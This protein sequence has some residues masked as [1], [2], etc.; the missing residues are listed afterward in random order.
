MP[1]IISMT[2][3][4]KN[5]DFDNISLDVNSYENILV[6]TKPLRIWFDKIEGLIRVN[7][8]S[9][10]LVLIGP[11]IYDPIYNKIRYLVGLTNG[12]MFAFFSKL[13]KKSMLLYL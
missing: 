2:I 10:Y 4:F 1:F 8:G 5:F 6:Y 9:G 11:K 12:I 3:E 13:R 7:D